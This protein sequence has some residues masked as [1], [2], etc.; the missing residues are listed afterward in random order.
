M[1]WQKIF[2]IYNNHDKDA[3]TVPINRWMHKEDVIAPT[4]SHKEEW[5]L[6]ICDNMD[7]PR[8]CYAKSESNQAEKDKYCMISLLRGT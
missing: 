4:L 8:G 6:A 5:S 1:G 7:G 3:T 2:I